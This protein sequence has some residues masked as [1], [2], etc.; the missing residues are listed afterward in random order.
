MII[1]MPMIMRMRVLSR[2]NIL[3]LVDA[4]AL[5]TALDRAIPRHGQPDRDVGVSG[6]AGTAAVLLVAEGFDHYGVV[7]SACLVGD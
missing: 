4:A 1:M 5:G 3:H 7:Q 2:P 6:A